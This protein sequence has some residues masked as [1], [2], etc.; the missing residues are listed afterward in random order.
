MTLSVR[1]ETTGP[2]ERRLSIEIPASEVQTERNATLREFKK[3]AVLP[4]FRKGHAPDHLVNKRYAD[5][6]DEETQTSLIRKSVRQALQEHKIRAA[7]SPRVEEVHYQ[8]G[9]TMALSV[10]VEVSPEFPLPDY[11]NLNLNT[12]SVEP[13]EEEVSSLLENMRRREAVYE[14]VSPETGAIESHLAVI[15]Y[16]A[17]IDGQPLTSIAPDARNLTERTDFWLPLRPDHFLPGLPQ[18]LHGA[19]TGETREV[20]VTFPQDF[21]HEALR[22]RTASFFVTIKALKREVLPELDD[23]LARKFG[24]ESL[25]KLRERSREVIRRQNEIQLANKQREEIARQL[26]TAVQFDVPE[27]ILQ[28]YT[29]EIVQDIVADNARR[30]IPAETLTQHKD[31]ILANA[32]RSAQDRVRLEFILARIASE[33]KISVT[34]NELMSEVENLAQLYAQPAEKLLKAMMKNGGLDRL[35][36]DLL[37]RKTLEH[38]RQLTLAAQQS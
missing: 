25:E 23:E 2:C 19:R 38:L 26:L 10:L 13:T 27:S 12:E 34:Q 28:H 1:I 4:G 15:D 31:Q 37:V 14:E 32:S 5:A 8:P 16:R 29:R 35:E 30:G 22:G 17:E 9:T 24:E 6:I 21:P 33:E 11:K 36:N 3:V 20:A 18:A 7:T